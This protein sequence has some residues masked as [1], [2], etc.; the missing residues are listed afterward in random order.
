MDQKTST[1]NED[2]IKSYGKESD[3]G[4]YFEV[5]VKYPERIQKQSNDLPF[6]PERVKNRKYNKLIGNLYNKKEDVGLVL[7]KVLE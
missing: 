6:L 5:D 7:Q 1:F 4:Y 2:F 3:I